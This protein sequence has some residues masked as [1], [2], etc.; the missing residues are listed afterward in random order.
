MNE[1]GGARLRLFFALWPPPSVRNELV[2]MG[3]AGGV[4]RGRAVPP[5][6]LH[7]TLVFLGETPAA[8]L[9]RVKTIARS[10]T[11]P[12]FELSLDRVG[13]FGRDAGCGWL[14]PTQCPRALQALQAG[15]QDALYAGGW[16]QDMR[17]FVPHVTLRRGGPVAEPGRPIHWRVD[18]F[19]L[20]ESRRQGGRL[21]Y[22]LLERYPLDR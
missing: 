17:A 20:A 14:G 13:V 2:R 8:Q 10:L 4:R 19:V 11:A 22:H 15:L 7:L 1:A 16:C 9:D 5:D 6:R 3:K 12:G 18:D 21:R